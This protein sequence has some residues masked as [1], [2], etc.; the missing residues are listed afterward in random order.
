MSAGQTLTLVS[1]AQCGLCDELA[2]ELRGLGVP[3][4]VVD[5]DSDA[6]LLRRYSESVPVL[7]LGSD[8]LAR[9][10]IAAG[11]LPALLRRAGALA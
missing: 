5:V 9:A 10:P 7:L 1:R 3:F 11:A 2:G 8:E 6:E 4:T